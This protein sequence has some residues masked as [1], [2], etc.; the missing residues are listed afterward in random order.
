MRILYLV[1][2]ALLRREKSWIVKEKNIFFPACKEDDHYNLVP[3]LIIQSCNQYDIF[4][5]PGC[6][7]SFFVFRMIPDL[8]AGWRASLA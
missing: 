8:P 5:I 1:I 3:A 6:P 2:A 4:V 7:E